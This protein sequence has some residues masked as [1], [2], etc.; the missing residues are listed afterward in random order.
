MGV[1]APPALARI[2]VVFTALLALSVLGARDA[3]SEN[4]PA[5]AGGAEATLLSNGTFASG[6]R[7]WAAHRARLR[8]VAREAHGTAVR[9]VPRRRSGRFFI[10]PAPRPVKSTE[11]TTLF[12]ARAAIRPSQ[13]RQKVCLRV[14]Q[15]VRGRV[16]RQTRSCA[17]G[18]RRWRLTRVRLLAV[19]CTGGQIGLSVGSRGRVGFDVDSVSLRATPASRSVRA[20]SVCRAPASSKAAASPAAAP[21][22][23]SAAAALPTRALSFLN[24]FPRGSLWNSPL[25]AEPALDPRSGEKIAYWLTQIRWPNMSL[26]RYATAV[27]VATPTSPRHAVSCTVYACPDL[28]QFGGVPIPAGTRP[29]PSSDGHLA[30]WDPVNNR[31]WD[32]WISGCPTACERTGSGGSFA[33]NST[34]PWVPFGANAAG[35]PLLAGIVHPEEIEAGRVDHPLIFG[36]PNVGVGR[37]CPAN[38]SDGRNTDSRA[39][40]EGTLL[41]LD[42]TLD[43]DALRIPQWQKTLARAMQRY[44]MYLADGGGSLSIG[45]ENPINRGDLW[46]DVGLMG[47][48][49]LF[50]V[51]FPWS[52]MRVLA[53][54]KPWC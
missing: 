6:L 20:P 4:R 35:W 14:Q 51:D 48:S 47:D 27:A 3:L 38:H 52:R 34:V 36:S 18:G 54:P 23:L 2:G 29:D 12:V 28:N 7:G 22:S 30:V 37:V 9:V 53:P 10:F 21:A 32:F 46:A 44:G 25:P 1:A 43:V 45:G 11:R 41:Q 39:L 24:P 16:I 13:R 33:T 40:Q 5:R 19:A 15:V 17:S 8:L 50:D 26:R 49:V 31:E 42:P